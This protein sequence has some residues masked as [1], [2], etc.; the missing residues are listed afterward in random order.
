M[1]RSS[2]TPNSPSFR[3]T[4]P[5]EEP[6]SPGALIDNQ[7][8]P[9]DARPPGTLQFG[10]DHEPAVERVAAATNREGLYLAAALLETGGDDRREA[11]PDAPD[12]EA[13]GLLRPV[14]AKELPG[15][16]EVGF[17]VETVVRIPLGHPHTQDLGQRQ[18]DDAC[19][20]SRET[21]GPDA[22]LLG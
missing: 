2:G 22:G 7:K 4:L 6:L 17:G 8:R 9:V 20:S 13:H 19:Q 3:I 5:K 18:G 14:L 1:I 11:R 10:V 21:P 16:F 12:A 15:G